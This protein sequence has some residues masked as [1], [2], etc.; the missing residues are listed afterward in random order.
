MSKIQEIKLFKKQKQFFELETREALLE[1]G[2]GYGK[3]MVGSLWL[4]WQTQKYPNTKWI[5]AARDYRQL[6]TSVDEE[7]EYLIN[8]TLGMK[9]DVHYSKTSGSPI[10]Y[11]FFGTNAKVFGMGAQNYDTAFRSGN[12]SGAWLDEI[13]Y[14]KPEAV[15]ALRGRIR[16][17]PELIRCTSSPKGFNHVHEDF[18]VNK[19]GP[20]ITAASYENPTLSPEYIESLKSTYSPK[21]FEQ[22]VLAKRLNLSVGQVYDEFNRTKHVKNC[23]QILEP[24]DQV[25]F[26]TDYN[27]SNY[28][29]V[30]MIFKNK[31]I[32]CIGEEHLQF[33]GSKEMAERIKNAYPDRSVIVVGDSTGNNKRDVAIDRTNYEVFK[34]AGIPTKHVHNPPVQSRIITAQSNLHHERI[35]VDPSCKNLIRDLELVSWKEDGKDIDKS[36]I[37]LSHSS[38]AFGYGVHYFMPLRWKSDAPIIIY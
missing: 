19:V 22:E 24:S 8:N 28:C 37:S 11:H 14:W 32:Y 36:D 4:A 38:D 10:E 21:L 6:K 35:V 13:D 12:Y 7:F 23:K 25:F 26:F 16:K 20:V 27:I 15:Q 1:A 18:Y 34:Q 29:G 5:M 2:I 33:K 3:S 9:R 17:A 31:I 30:Y